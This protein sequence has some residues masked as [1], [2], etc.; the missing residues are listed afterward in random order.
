MKLSQPAATSQG[1]VTRAEFTI[2][3]PP[4]TRPVNFLGP[5]RDGMGIITI[6]TGHPQVPTLRIYVAFTVE[7]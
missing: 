7:G 3:I 6:E 1:N 2:G 5:K 4:G